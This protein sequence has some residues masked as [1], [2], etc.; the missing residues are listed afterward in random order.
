MMSESQRRA[1]GREIIL[2]RGGAAI[3]QGCVCGRV[4]LAAPRWASRPYVV[5]VVVLLNGLGGFSQLVINRAVE[6]RLQLFLCCSLPFLFL[7]C[8]V[9]ERN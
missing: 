2:F 7:Q 9:P 4:Y 6:V 5:S 8:F 1:S 3:Q